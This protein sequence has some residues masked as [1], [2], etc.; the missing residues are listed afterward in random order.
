MKLFTAHSCFSRYARFGLSHR[1]AKVA[2]QSLLATAIVFTGA[3]AV[4]LPTKP[5]IAAESTIRSVRGFLPDLRFKLSG[6]NGQT[7]TESDLNNKVVLLFFGYANCPDICPTTLAQ[8]AM[9]RGLLGEQAEQ[10]QIVFISVDPH[11]DTPERL[12]AYVDAFQADALGLTGSEKQIAD[13]ARRYRVAYQIEKPK[14]DNPNVYE[15]AHGRGVYIF[16]QKGRARFLAS[17]SES[18][19][20]LVEKVEELL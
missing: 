6:T 10:V 18:I 5:A 14:T 2:A 17:D 7:V 19:E 16:D 3:S 1:L 13:V 15:V 12:K 8:L 4:F 20:R 9:A 11:R